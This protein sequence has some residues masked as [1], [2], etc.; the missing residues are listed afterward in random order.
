ML[1][2]DGRGIRFCLS[3]YAAWRM[4]NKANC[5]PFQLFATYLIYWSYEYAQRN[6]LPSSNCEA[7][8]V[9]T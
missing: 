1:R 9:L 5:L 3:L 4:R 8:V 7:Q 2:V 6:R